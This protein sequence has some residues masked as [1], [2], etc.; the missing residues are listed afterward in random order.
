VARIY[1]GQPVCALL[2]FAGAQIP[3]LDAIAPMKDFLRTDD[4]S[5]EGRISPFTMQVY[6][7]ID[8]AQADYTLIGNIGTRP[9][10]EELD[11]TRTD[12]QPDGDRPDGFRGGQAA[13]PA[14]G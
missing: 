12:D 10:D 9:G 7:G 1:R 13:P 6:K 5:P 4:W 14:L 8:Y 3:A 11:P 2:D